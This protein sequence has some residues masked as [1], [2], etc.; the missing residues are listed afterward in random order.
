MIMLVLC[1]LLLATVPVFSDQIFTD[2]LGREIRVVPVKSPDE[3]DL[4]QGKDV[5]V[6]GFMTVY[7]EVPLFELNPEFKSTGDV[8]RFYENYFDSEWEH[9]KHGELIWVQAFEGERLLGWATFQMEEDKENAAYMNLLVVDPKEQGRGIGKYLTFSICSEDLYP[10]TKEIS[11]LLRKINKTGRKFYE[12]I[13]FTDFDYDRQDN[14]VDTSLL[15]GLRWT[16][17]Q[18][19]L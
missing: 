14:F 7:E 2:S 12:N 19:P 4:I 15:T 16:K 13:G 9:Y 1:S 11:V 8:R 3:I 10:Q 5:L 17:N 18:L 6:R